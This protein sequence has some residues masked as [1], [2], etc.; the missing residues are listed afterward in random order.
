MM[1]VYA[2]FLLIFTMANIAL[3]QVV[4]LVNLLLLGIYKTNVIV[5]L[6]VL[7]SYFMWSVFVMA[8][9]QNNFGNL[10]T[11][12]IVRFKDVNF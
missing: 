1:P 2:A 7:W 6:L 3:E 9:Q 5:L 12:F 11:S 4:L 8:L 10:K